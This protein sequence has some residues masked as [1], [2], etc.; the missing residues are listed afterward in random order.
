LSG[1]NFSEIPWPLSLWGPFCRTFETRPKT[2]IPKGIGPKAGF[3]GEQEQR[4]RH[5]L[6]LKKGGGEPGFGSSPVDPQE[7]MGL[8]ANRCFKSAWSEPQK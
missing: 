6:I 3:W 7:T 4:S 2:T 5:K 8:I 1:N